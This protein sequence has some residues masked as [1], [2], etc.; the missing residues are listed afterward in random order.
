M[1]SFMTSASSRL[2]HKL[3]WSGIF[4]GERNADANACGLKITAYYLPGGDPVI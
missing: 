3:G 2:T 1:I 4:R